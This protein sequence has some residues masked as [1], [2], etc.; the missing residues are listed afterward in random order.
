MRERKK[1]E[2]KRERERN[3]CAVTSRPLGSYLRG[4]L[5]GN[6]V[7][8]E[9]EAAQRGHAAQRL[10]GQRAAQRVLAAGMRKYVR[11]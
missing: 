11:K 6:K 8:V 10:G 9:L 4:Q 1:K 5:V 7:S 3:K 2:K